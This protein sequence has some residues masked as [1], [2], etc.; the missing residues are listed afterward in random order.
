MQNM[1]YLKT[2][3]KN[4][5]KKE[6]NEIFHNQPLKKSNQIS[7]FRFDEYGLIRISGRICRKSLPSSSNCQITLPNNHLLS[8]LLLTFRKYNHFGREL[9]LNLFGESFG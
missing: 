1:K 3:K 2:V 4:Y 6:L 9:T 5:L 8:T 7:L